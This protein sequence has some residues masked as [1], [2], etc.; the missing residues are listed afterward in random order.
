MPG[1][2]VTN[3]TSPT[4]R[5]A[6]P[7]H[8]HRGPPAA[9]PDE[10]Q[11]RATSAREPSC[12]LVRCRG[13]TGGDR[14]QSDL[15]EG[16]PTGSLGRMVLTVTE[17]A[18]EKILELR[19]QEDEPDDARPA[20]RGHRRPG[21][22]VHLRPHV[23]PGGRGRRRRRRRGRG[24]RASCRSSSRSTA[25]TPLRGATLD[26]PT[27]DGQQGLVLRNPNRPDPLSGAHVELSGTIAE[28][29]QPAARRSRS[30]RRSPRTAASPPLDRVE[31][32]VV[33]V[34][35]GG[36]CQGAPCRP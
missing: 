11:E 25:S 29:V 18:R 28:K 2:G 35:M 12:D 36:G 30:T 34:T 5:S 15:C 1:P 6:T 7:D 4:P 13:L 9:A 21:R 32:E 22:R 16:A 8:E 10:P 14:R 27:T 33:Y 17:P 3:M 23:R 31:G 19:A 20:H 26:L 24:R